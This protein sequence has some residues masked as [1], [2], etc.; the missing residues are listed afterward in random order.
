MAQTLE[1]LNAAAI[2]FA[3]NRIAHE[4]AERNHEHGEIVLL[5][6]P[7]GG[8]HFAQRLATALAGIC[9]APPPVGTLDITM[10]RDDLDTRALPDFHPSHIPVD[11]TGKTVVL[12]DDVI[13]S[14]RTARAALDALNDLGR[15]RRVQ[16]VALIDRGNR[17]LPIAPDFVGK[18]VPTSPLERIEV[19]WKEAA[20][21]DQVELLKP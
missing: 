12:V 21:I 20:G 16:L 2:Q 6:I 5:G 3:V 18:S 9:P 17:E 19:R 13:F 15:P 10:H 1:L 14:G 8:S 11:L 4:I 7:T